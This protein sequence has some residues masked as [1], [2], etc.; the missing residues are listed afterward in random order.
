MNV[1]TTNV[2]N[3]LKL[4]EKE[5]NKHVKSLSLLDQVALYLEFKSVLSQV[6]HNAKRI[7]SV[8]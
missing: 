3:C 1:L 8:R 6:K 7:K 5:F 2:K 4:S